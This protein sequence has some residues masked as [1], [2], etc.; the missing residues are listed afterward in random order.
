MTTPAPFHL[1]KLN[2]R[3]SIQLG[4]AS[5]AAGLLAS[6]VALQPAEA[7]DP[8]PAPFTTPFVVALP[9]Y[10]AKLPVASLS[11]APTL[12]ANV[13]GGE[14]GRGAHQRLNDFA[15]QKY[16]ELH[17]KPNYVHSFHP[18]L[19]PQ[20]IWGY[21]G[22]FPGPTF[23]ER[24]GVP[25]MVRIYNDLPA[26]ASGFGSPEISTHLHNLHTPSESD[27]F[28]GDYYSATKYGPTLTAPGAFQD[29]L[30]PN[31]YAGYDDPRYRDASGKPRGDPR[32]AL[33]SLW[34]HDHRLDFTSGN[35]YRGL[36]GYYLLFDDLDSGDELDPNPKAL[37][38]PS[39][40]G[41]YDISLAIQ[42]RQFDSSGYLFFDQFATKGMLG[43]KFCVNGKI[44][45][46][47]NVERRKYRFRVLNGGLS[48]L[49]EFYLVSESG[50]NQSF[51]HIANDGNLLPAPL[52]NTRKVHLA[53]AERGD[54][55]IDFK[56]YPPGTKLYLVNRLVQLDPRKPEGPEVNTR[57]ANGLLTTA[58]TRIM[59][60]DV[61]DLPVQ[62]DLSR[63]P[64]L[65]RELPPIDLSEVKQTRRWEF[66]RENEVWTVNGKIFDPEKPA[67][68]PK[69]GTA[70]IWVLKGK[71]SWVHPVHIHFEEG[72]ILSR[73]GKPPAPH[74]AGRKDVYVL[75]DG[76]ELRVFI[77][78]R[79]FTGK[80]MMHCHNLVH[81]DHAMMV[82][83][84]IVE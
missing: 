76:D 39:G 18:E 60:F 77:R 44:Q 4:V 32:E 24:Y 68:R 42:D 37:R 9:V 16:Y 14:C 67:A 40:V 8:P 27:G 83:F 13:S 33:G 58:G 48:R 34:Y 36:A 80:Y 62:P 70:E 20:T 38:L 7:K 71:G 81:E 49:Y 82:R 5:T 61:G 10:Q 35:V 43:D 72:R 41:K 11:P 65:L 17:V 73:N 31:A 23:V 30:Y 15:P 64:N 51:D 66:D 12:N 21:D 52:R 59:R 26:N 45:P 56:A 74:E 3:Q 75:E 78:F 25:I 69:R 29:H 1:P 55:V 57:G 19:P 22:I 54:I 2:R 79:D 47:F 63:V 28:A 84:D 6:K 53:P 50:L 46:F